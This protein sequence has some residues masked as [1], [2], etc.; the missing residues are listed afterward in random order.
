[1]R[2]R[3]EVH[4]T[5]GQI[6]TI[7]GADHYTYMPCFTLDA[8]DMDDPEVPQPDIATIRFLD[9]D[10]DDIEDEL[11]IAADKVA[12]IREVKE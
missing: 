5:G 3:Y 4:L 9:E 7:H 1:M 6:L 11:F 2:K 12:A 8:A 10:G